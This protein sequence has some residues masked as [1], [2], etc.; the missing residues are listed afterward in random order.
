MP[1][2]EYRSSDF[3]LSDLADYEDKNDFKLKHFVTNKFALGL[4]DSISIGDAEPEDNIRKNNHSSGE[5]AISYERKLPLNDSNIIKKL[6]IQDEL[7]TCSM[8]T[9]NGIHFNFDNPFDTEYLKQ[10]SFMNLRHELAENELTNN[11]FSNIVFD[12]AINKTELCDENSS[13]VT[14]ATDLSV[15]SDV[16]SNTKTYTSTPN[17]G[18]RW[19]I[20]SYF[21]DIVNKVMDGLALELEVT[22][23]SCSSST[24]TNDP[25]I[26]RNDG[27][28][29]QIYSRDT[30]GLFSAHKL[31][32][33]IVL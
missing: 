15:I 3:L 14:M 5:S 31:R 21:T 13:H 19:D 10:E 27:K 9:S 18:K 16:T 11:A 33:S 25:S 4:K 26:S 6:E 20:F 28:Q 29:I 23:T 22:N 8:A 32:S 17:T 2:Y 1:I 24:T 7:S 30:S 12:K